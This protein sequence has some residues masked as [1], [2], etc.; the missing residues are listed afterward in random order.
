[1][2]TTFKELLT[3]GRSDKGL[4]KA[5]EKSMN[6]YGGPTSGKDSIEQY[7][8]KKNKEQLNEALR[9]YFKTKHGQKMI[10]IFIEDAGIELGS[11]EAEYERDHYENDFIWD[12]EVQIENA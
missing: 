3:E 11:E 4:I 6:Q 12:V 2:T 5:I 9:A 10:D 1:M 8:E 7:F